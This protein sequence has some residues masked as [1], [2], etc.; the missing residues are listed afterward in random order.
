MVWSTRS[1]TASKRARTFSKCAAV[2]EDLRDVLLHAVHLGEGHELA[3]EAAAFD[4][5]LRLALEHVVVELVRGREARAVDGG[6]G[7]DR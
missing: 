1:G 2:A 7:A 6:E 3:A 5:L 4:G